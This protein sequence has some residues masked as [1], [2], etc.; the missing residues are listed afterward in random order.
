MAI[1]DSR[2]QDAARMHAAHEHTEM[3]GR[4]GTWGAF[5]CDAKMKAGRKRQ[6]NKCPTKESLQTSISTHSTNNKP[7]EE[8]TH[9]GHLDVL[10]CRCLHRLALEDRTAVL[11]ELERDN[12][13]VGW[14]DADG[15]RRAVGLVP[16]D[17]VDVDDPLLA[18][19]LGDLALTTLVLSAHNPDL[20]VL[21]NRDGA[22]LI[23][24][25]M[26]L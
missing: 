2:G 17:T 14:V 3:C 21:A 15:S 16:L 25:I 19:D 6:R 26:N 9:V 7:R 8:K 20:V 13:D 5:G 23:E 24:Y 18:V 22:D 4:I 1:R 10:L 12:D 11:V